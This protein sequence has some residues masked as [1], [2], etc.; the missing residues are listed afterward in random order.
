MKNFN[1]NQLLSEG[2]KLEPHQVD[3]VWFGLKHHWH[4]NADDMG[5]GKTLQAL[6]IAFFHQR[7]KH[8]PVLCVVPAYLASN[9]R[10]EINKFSATNKTVNVV[11]DGKEARQM[12]GTKEAPEDFVICSYAKIRDNPTLLRKFRMVIWDE[13][14]YL[15]NPESK[16]TQRAHENLENFAPDVVIQLSGTP[17]KNRIPEFYSQMTIPS[18]NK[19]K[20][21][22]KDV[23]AMYSYHQFCSDFCFSRNQRTPYG[24]VKIFEGMKNIPK[25]KG[26][27]KGKYLRRKSDV[28]DLPDQV[29]NEVEV[30][31]KDDGVLEEAWKEFNNGSPGANSKNKAQAAKLIAPATA[32]YVNGLLDKGLGPIVIFTDHVESSYLL[33]Q[34]IKGKSGRI[35]GEVG[36]DTRASLVSDFQDGKLDALILTIGAGSTGITLHASNQ[37]VV[38]DPSWVPGDNEQAWKRIHRMGQDQTCFFHHMVG[39]KV[40]KKIR[41]LLEKKEKV[42]KEILDK[43]E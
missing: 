27:L 31:F 34:K 40:G 24:N 25:L 32:E 5:L 9:W 16:I 8:F 37:C 7:N 3:G 13:S 41:K 14:H 15:K 12:R 36:N 22:G 30:E 23:L 26:L 11:K 43:E 1:F 2:T 39:G 10:N 6:T 19:R 4:I 28:V 35:S 20:T 17:I 33:K 21:S 42:L 38:N 29:H 18:Y